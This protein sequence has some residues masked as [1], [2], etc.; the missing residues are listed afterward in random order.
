MAATLFQ[1]RLLDLIEAALLAGTPAWAAYYE[2]HRTRPLPTAASQGVSLRAPK[3]FSDALLA[4]VGA[5]VQWTTQLGI[6]CIARCGAD[7][8]PDAAVAPLLADVHARLF[9]AIGTLA[10]AGFTLQPELRIEWDQAEMDER[11]GAAALV[12]STTHW[13]SAT[14]LLLD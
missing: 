8:T 10:A 4:G 2:R 13:G 12:F 7:T 6:E 1:Q 11:I 9:G 14:S 3:A 5:E